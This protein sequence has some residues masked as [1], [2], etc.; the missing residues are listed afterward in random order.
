[1]MIVCLNLLSLNKFYNLCWKLN[2]KSNNFISRS[3]Y[4]SLP[5]FLTPTLDHPVLRLSP[6]IMSTFIQLVLRYKKTACYSVIYNVN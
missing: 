6:T 4:I 3:K 5:L 2:L 1:M